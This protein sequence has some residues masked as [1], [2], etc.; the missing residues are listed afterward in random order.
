LF[1]SQ[2]TTMFQHVEFFA[3]DPILSLNEAFLAD[4][5]PE[6]VNLSIGIYADDQA[7]LPALDA[8]HQAELRLAAANTAKPY[9][10]SEGASNFRGAVQALLFGASHEVVTSRRA[11]TV[12]SVGSSGGLKLGAEFIKRWFPGSGVWVSNPTWDPHRAMFQSAGIEVREYPYFENGGG[13]CFDAMLS[14]LDALPAHSVVLLHA[15]CH[16]PTGADLTRDQWITLIDLLKARQLIPYLDLAYQGF[17]EGIEEDA[18]AVRALAAAGLSFLVA[19]SFSKSMGLY[20]ERCGALTVVCPDAEQAERVLGQLKATAR[21][22]YS[23]PPIHG[24]QIVAMILTDPKLRGPW[25]KDLE[26]MRTRIQAMRAQLHAA[27]VRRHPAGKFGYLLTQRGMFSY[28]GLSAVQVDQLRDEH[29]IYLVRSGRICIA[30][31][32]TSNV[33]IVAQAIAEKLEHA[34]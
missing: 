23:S 26:R 1:N 13:V 33:E 14:A 5:R 11:A 20:G 2:K 25:E 30:G 19:N 17:A 7:R 10:P 29:A 31:L 9:L 16:N 32:N 18:F 4:P 22:T 12:Q 34:R 3:G 27:L 15:C 28:T 6:K 21:R 24:G 8:V